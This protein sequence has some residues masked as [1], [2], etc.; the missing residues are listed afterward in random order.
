MQG[1]E[2]GPAVALPIRLGRGEARMV[3]FFTE[4][5][6]L[7]GRPIAHRWQW[8]GRIVQDRAV[9][10]A[11]QAWRAYTAKAIDRPGSWQVAVVDT[12]TGSVL[13]EQRFDAQ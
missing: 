10:P 4:L 8:E 12:A 7:A 13:A 9:R 5:R 11:S 3:Y 1:L 6:G 2:P